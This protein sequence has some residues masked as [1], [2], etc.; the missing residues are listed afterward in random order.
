MA[1]IKYQ[2]GNGKGNRAA[3][4]CGKATLQTAMFTRIKNEVEGKSETA[5]TRIFIAKLSQ[6]HGEFLDAMEKAGISYMDAIAQM[7]ALTPIRKAAEP[8]IAKE[9]SAVAR[10]LCRKYGNK[11][12]DEMFASF[13]ETVGRPEFKALVIELV[14]TSEKKHGRN[15][16]GRIRVRPERKDLV[17]NAAKARAGRKKK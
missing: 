10:M 2:E 4:T 8:R 17:G 11:T 3:F 13:V 9:A 5:Q 7:I 12:P 1:V 15:P 16:Q 6:K 14:D